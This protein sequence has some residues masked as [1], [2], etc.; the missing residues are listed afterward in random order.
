MLWSGHNQTST[1]G[2]SENDSQ[3]LWL[4]AGIFMSPDFIRSCPL[5]HQFQDFSKKIWTMK[6][7]NAIKNSHKKMSKALKNYG[8]CHISCQLTASYALGRKYHLVLAFLHRLGRSVVIA[9]LQQVLSR[10]R[11]ELKKVTH[12]HF[13]TSKVCIASCPHLM[14]IPVV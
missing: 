1:G 11:H 2:W 8:Q 10:W 4:P 3:N 5:L 12:S 13:R 6:C 9:L 14:G 7:R